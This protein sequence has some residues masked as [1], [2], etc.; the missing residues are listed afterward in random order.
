MLDRKITIYTAI[1]SDLSKDTEGYENVL[2]ELTHMT[3]DMEKARQIIESCESGNKR[4][5]FYYPPCNINPAEWELLGE[6][7]DGALYL[8]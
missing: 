8:G 5:I 1:G 6:I 7:L 3:E 4:L 2:M